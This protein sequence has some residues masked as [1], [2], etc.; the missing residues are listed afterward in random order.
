M[1]L[2]SFFPVSIYLCLLV[3]STV[4]GDAMAQDQAITTYGEMTASTIAS[5]YRTT[6]AK[7]GIS[8]PFE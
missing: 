6:A 3:V 5:T 1:K 7:R 8:V 4:G 2:S